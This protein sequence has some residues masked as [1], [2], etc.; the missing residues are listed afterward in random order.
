MLNFFSSIVISY[1]IT[2]T[3]EG[4]KVELF[5]TGWFSLDYT[6]LANKFFADYNC[7]NENS[8]NLIGAS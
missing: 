2:S 7:L 6:E 8:L 3:F 4:L 1:S 5:T